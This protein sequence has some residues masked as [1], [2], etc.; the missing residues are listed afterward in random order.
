MKCFK[1]GI[2]LRIKNEMNDKSFFYCWWFTI[3]RKYLWCLQVGIDCLLLNT[4]HDDLLSVSQLN[5]RGMIK[6]NGKNNSGDIL[7]QI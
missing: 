5:R 6:D 3:D 2:P 1:Y 7:N 4:I